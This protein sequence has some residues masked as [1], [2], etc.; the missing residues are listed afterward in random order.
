MVVRRKTAGDFSKEVL[1]LLETFASQSALAVFNARLFRELERKSTELQVAGEHKS[2]FLASMSHELRTPL[3]AVIGF[4]EVLLERMFGDLNERQE[5]YLQDILNSGNHLLELLN[6]ILDLSKV[7][8]GRMELEHSVFSVR[9]VIEQAIALV[10][11]R[12]ALH[13]IALS[14]EIDP[15]LDEIES[16]ELRFKQV[17]VNLLSNAVKFTPDDGHVAVRATS[18]ER[19]LTVTVKDD[20][21]GIPPEDQERIFEAFH[22][23]RRGASREEGTGLGLTLCRR[24]VALM[25]GEMTLQTEVGVGSTFAFTIPVRSADAQLG[26]D[27]RNDKDPVVVVIDDDRASL[28][29]MSAYLDGQRRTP[30]P[31]PRWHRGTGGNSAATTGR[32]SARYPVAGHRRLGG[33]GAAPDRSA[34]HEAARDRRLDRGREAARP[35]GGCCRLLDQA[36]GPRRPARCPAA[37]AGTARRRASERELQ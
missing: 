9:G 33:P 6:E 13:R 37:T 21:I 7:E 16:D 34:V 28:D 29:L 32:C 8:A 2:A 15:T 27:R 4:S 20:G 17:I 19:R 11:E 30:G 26:P 25:G 35:G 5:E 23:G 14:V 3:N 12:A 36:G 1:D 22:Q 24:I 18:T 31:G 10:R